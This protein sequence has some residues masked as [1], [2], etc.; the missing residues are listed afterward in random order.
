[1]TDIA[2]TAYAA[3]SAAGDSPAT[4]AASYGSGGH[5]LRYDPTWAAWAG[6]LPH[7]TEVALQSMVQSSRLY[8]RLDRT[9][10]LAMWC[11]ERVMGQLD[12]E[13]DFAIQFGSS[14]GAT[15]LWE[16]AYAEFLTTGRVPATTSP[17][18]T[19]G[20]ISS[21]VGQHLGGRGYR[22]EHSVTCSTA[23]H[24]IATAVAWLRAGLAR[25]FLAGAAEAPLTDFGLAQLRALR[26]YSTASAE[27]E[28]PCRPL[29]HKSQ[30]S[31]VLG[32]GV[33][34]FA[35]ER[36]PE[37]AP[38]A[39]ILGMGFHQEAIDSPTGIDPRG[40]GF[41][42][43]MELAL[44]PDSAPPDLIIAHAPGTR[45]GDAAELAAIE[46]CF[47]ADHPPVVSTKY[48]QG[49]TFG[50]SGGLSL[51]LAILYLQNQLD[52]PLPFTRGNWRPEP[53]RRVLINSAGFG[54]NCVSILLGDRKS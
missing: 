9:V 21:W 47:G 4:V 42:A 19:L 26:I 3:A 23:L 10:Q 11:S 1:M 27:A 51:E 44:G 53:I 49:H 34:C 31:L 50:A 46:R 28:W 16:A 20:N 12:W 35:L 24:A 15:Q 54:G 33:A 14:R 2:L 5:A 48:C 25:R 40:S 43:T 52:G 39:W 13:Q 41:A 18:T 37:R 7:S 45:Q 22:G 32:E 29:V 8:P 30:N 17:F 38:L 36:A 6:H